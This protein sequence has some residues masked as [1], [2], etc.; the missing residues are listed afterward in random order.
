MNNFSAMW[1]FPIMDH[2]T[3]EYANRIHPLMQKRVERLLDALKKDTNVVRVVLLA[4]HWSSAA[5]ASAI[6]ICI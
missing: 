3:L 1:D 5:A 6:L 2:V 4:V